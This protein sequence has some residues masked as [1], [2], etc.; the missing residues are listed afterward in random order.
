MKQITLT[1][2]EYRTILNALDIAHDES[3]WAEFKELLAKLVEHP[4]VPDTGDVG[5]PSVG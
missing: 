1:E 4:S 2:E 5:K 3:R